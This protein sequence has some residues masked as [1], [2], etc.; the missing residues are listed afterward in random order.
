MSN[1]SQAAPPS[2]LP[3]FTKSTNQYSI[4]NFFPRRNTT[5]MRAYFQQQANATTSLDPAVI[6]A[7][8]IAKS[9]G[10]PMK[11]GGKRTRRAVS[12]RRRSS[13]RK[14]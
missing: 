5:G 3:M 11:K 12:R 4:A 7:A 6:R 1:P 8:A 13:R 2:A 9:T 14:H 10:G